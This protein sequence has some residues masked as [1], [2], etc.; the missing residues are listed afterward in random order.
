MPRHPTVVS[1]TDV[2]AQ[3]RAMLNV[4]E[5]GNAPILITRHGMVIATLAPPRIAK[6]LRNRLHRAYRLMKRKARCAGCKRRRR[7]R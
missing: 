4:V 3:I 2:R 5:F 1:V 6:A 7:E